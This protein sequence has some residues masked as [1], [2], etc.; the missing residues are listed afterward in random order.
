M[1]PD[2]LFQQKFMDSSTNNKQ[3]LFPLLFKNL[4]NNMKNYFLVWK[5][6]YFLLML[7]K[8]KEKLLLMLLKLKNFNKE[9]QLFS[10]MMMVIIFTYK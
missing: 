5:K 9:L 4:Q 7:M 10:K 1:L 2:F 3:I 6:V 8:M